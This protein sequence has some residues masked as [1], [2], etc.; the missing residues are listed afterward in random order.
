MSLSKLIA[1]KKQIQMA[2]PA[3]LRSQIQDVSNTVSSQR[4]QS[5]GMRQ[6]LATLTSDVSSTKQALR[7]GFTKTEQ[8]AAQVIA[9]TKSA[10]QTSLAPV[11]GAVDALSTQVAK[12]AQVIAQTK[13]AIQTSLAP[14][15][16]AV[17]ALSTQVAKASTTASDALRGAQTAQSKIQQL[18]TSVA[19]LDAHLAQNDMTCT[20]R[21]SIAQGAVSAVASDIASIRQGL[22]N[23]VQ[24]KNAAAAFMNSDIHLTVTEDQEISAALLNA[25][26]AGTL[27]KEFS[28]TLAYGLDDALHIW[29]SFGPVLVPSAEEVADPQVAAPTVKWKDHGDDA[30]MFTNGAVALSVIFDTD[31]GV[32]KTYVADE[33]C[34]VDVQ[35][36][37]TDVWHGVTVTKKTITFTVVA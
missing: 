6:A 18:D 7:E 11:Q 13:S 32:T 10:I 25:A 4:V 5:G 29:A 15:Q 19:T 24:Y 31:A 23:E 26:A 37:A 22:N 30:P 8:K 17:D 3:M 33:T 1:L 9:Q 16:G 2:P 12:A 36:S 14:V 35:I 27:I 20:Q 21:A 34:T 28:A